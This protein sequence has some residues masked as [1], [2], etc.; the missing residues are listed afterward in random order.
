[1]LG[2]FWRLEQRFAVLAASSKFCL[3][4]QFLSKILHWFRAHIKHEKVNDFVEN[5][6]SC[7]LLEGLSCYQRLSLK[8]GTGNGGMGN[9]ERGIS[10]RGNL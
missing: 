5:L 2:N 4:E 1:M 9:G 3:S 7:D 6:N 10:K 8:Q